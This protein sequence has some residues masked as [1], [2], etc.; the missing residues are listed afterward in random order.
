MVPS[1]VYLALTVVAWVWGTVKGQTKVTP[2]PASEF[3][4]QPVNTTVPE[5]EQAVLKCLVASPAHVCR[6]YFLELGIDFFDSR[7]SPMLVKDFSPAH[8]RDCSIRIK[9][10]RKIQQGQWVCQALRYHTSVFSVTQPAVLRVLKKGETVS[11]KDLPHPTEPGPTNDPESERSDDGVTPSNNVEF[12]TSHEDYIQNAALGDSVILKCQINKPITSCSWVMPHGAFFNLSQDLT[13]SSNP[14][15]YAEDYRLEGDLSEGNCTLRV[16]EVRL[17][18]EGD[19]RCLVESGD[20]HSQGPLLH[21]HISQHN[22]STHTHEGTPLVA[23]E[24]ISS[25][26][27]LVTVLVVMCSALF[28]IVVLLFTCLYRRVN[29]NSEETR[30][31]LPLSPRSSLDLS[32]KTLPSTNLTQ[33][34]VLAVEVR[35]KRLPCLPF[36]QYNQYLDMSGNS[37]EDGYVMMP[38]SSLRSSTT[39]RTTLS[40]LSTLPCGR[41]RSASSSTTL[42]VEFPHLTNHVDNPSYNASP[43]PA[44]PD[45]LYKSDHVYEEIKEKDPTEKMEKITEVTTPVTP[46]YTNITADSE[47]YLIPRKTPPS[48]A[49]LAKLTKECSRPPL[50][51]PPLVQPNEDPDVEPLTS[52]KEA[53]P[54]SRI[55]ECGLV[56]ASPTN[57]SPVS[58]SQQ[59]PISSV[60]QSS[61]NPGPGYSRVGSVSPV[62]P[63]ERYD[64]PRPFNPMEGYDIPRAVQTATALQSNIPVP[65]EVC[66]E[67]IPGTIV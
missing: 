60:Q 65:T 53:N 47:G 14:S 27:V 16:R 45:S 6:W 19:W 58:P 22:Y 23:E 20:H 35:K 40:T 56:P 48:E 63:M 43:L 25:G 64:T 26:S 24:E 59:S 9:K 3:L 36:E 52:P 28:M 39:S 50:P 34:S 1:R 51:P 21:L 49:L 42:S 46:T 32:C 11:W 4:I 31:I 37:S 55:G 61:N 54:Y 29:G 38:G 66:M 8:N 44:R 2:S 15:K 7:V 12:K 30:K 33:A 57:P 5:G 13:N 10:V 41:S 17:Q 62:D 18:D 67:T